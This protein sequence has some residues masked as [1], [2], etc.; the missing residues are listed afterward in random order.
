MVAGQDAATV[1]AQ[2]EA[3]KQVIRRLF[4]EVW[5]RG[6]LDL[7]DE[8]IAPNAVVHDPSL[9]QEPPPGPAGQKQVVGMFRA[10]FPDCRFTFEDI[11]AEGDKVVYRWTARGTHL[12]PFAGFPPTRRH[13]Q[14]AGISISRFQDGKIAEGW[15]NY[16]PL[17]LIRQ[18]GIGRLIVRK[19]IA[20]VGDAARTVTKPLLGARQA[21]RAP[22]QSR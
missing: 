2:E 1:A 3:N 6:N 19:A 13:G 20:V 18:L 8:I 11:I 5:N 22:Q 15:D 10:A 17:G 7:L 21:N 12:G 9:Q 16:H 4:A 14:I